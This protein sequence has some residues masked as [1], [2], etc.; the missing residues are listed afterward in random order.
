[1][2]FCLVG[3]SSSGKSTIERELENNGVERVI[4]YTTRPPRDGETNGNHYHFISEEEFD[5]LYTNGAFT[6]VAQ[7]REWWY[8]LSVANIDYEGKPCVAVV[9]PKGYHEIVEKLGKE[10][11]KSIYISVSERERI[12]RQLG[13]GD[14]IDE[15][16]RRIHTDRADFADFSNEA[17]FIV[18]NFDVDKAV[19][20]AYIIIRCSNK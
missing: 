18:D 4:S 2:I 1:M 15:I 20:M 13:R 14:K 12:A 6:E 8:G 19:E 10:H 5:T 11:V 17:D 9:T 16:I 7:Y 3:E